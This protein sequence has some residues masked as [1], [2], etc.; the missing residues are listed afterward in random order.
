MMVRRSTESLWLGRLALV[1]AAKRA[2]IVTISIHFLLVHG[3]DVSAL[4]LT[5]K[6]VH[7]LIFK[8]FLK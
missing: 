6:L 7:H 2:H 5:F 4:L 8:V 1:N 3:L